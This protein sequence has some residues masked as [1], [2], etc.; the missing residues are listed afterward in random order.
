MSDLTELSFINLSFIATGALISKGTIL[1]DILRI[2]LIT[3]F[4]T[5]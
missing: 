2:L 5:T 4:Q 1:F 3:K